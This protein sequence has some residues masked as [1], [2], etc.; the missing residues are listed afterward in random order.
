MP[1]TSV[2]GFSASKLEEDE[3]GVFDSGARLQ[4]VMKEGP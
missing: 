1:T 2:K 3:R 4:H